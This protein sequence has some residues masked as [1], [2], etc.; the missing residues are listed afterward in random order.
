MKPGCK[1]CFEAKSVLYFVCVNVENP[2]NQYYH[3]LAGLK[4]M[5]KVPVKLVIPPPDATEQMAQP[6]SV[7]TPMAQDKLD[8][9]AVRME[10]MMI[11]LGQ[12]QNQI[13]AQQQKITDFET[14]Q[15]F[16]D[17]LPLPENVKLEA[18]RRTTDPDDKTEKE[19]DQMIIT[20]FYSKSSPVIQATMD[21]HKGQ[22][23]SLQDL[24]MF[25]DNLEKII[26][27]TR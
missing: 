9:M 26:K 7:P 2:S 21:K 25:C 1:I 13:V 20:Q 12:M 22:I 6:P 17:N 10:K 27:D 4:P 24:V 18:L 11:I 3:I 5:S 23:V 19:R 15:Q 16:R 8:L 14:D